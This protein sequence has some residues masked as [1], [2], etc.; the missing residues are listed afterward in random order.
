MND[1][2]GTKKKGALR[3]DGL[4]TELMKVFTLM[5]L[6]KVLT[7]CA[8]ADEAVKSIE[9]I[10]RFR[11]E[12]EAPWPPRGAAGRYCLRVPRAPAVASPPTRRTC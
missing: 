7:I 10:G 12:G 4:D 6:S 2:K 8:N 1:K 9:R 3:L 11:D 5:K